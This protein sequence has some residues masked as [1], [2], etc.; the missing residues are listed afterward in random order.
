MR[1]NPLVAI[2][3]DEIKDPQHWESVLVMGRYEEIGN[4][5]ETYELRQFAWSLLQ[6]R[7]LW[8]EPAYVETVLDG[9]PRSN[10]PL[11]FRIRMERLTGHR[12]SNE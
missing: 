4:T 7:K 5:S 12:A 1:E 2:E 11:Y 3:V 6:R 10:M 8:W 9:K